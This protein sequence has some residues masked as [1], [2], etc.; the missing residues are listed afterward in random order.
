M[1]SPHTHRP[2]WRQ[3]HISI[4]VA[5]REENFTCHFSFIVFFRGLL[6]YGHKDKASS[7]K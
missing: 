4:D 6:I 3:I 7:N 1:Y 2:R 5:R